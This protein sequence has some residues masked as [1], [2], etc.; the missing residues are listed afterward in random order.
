MKLH[1]TLN[2]IKIVSHDNIDN[3]L[4]ICIFAFI[5][6]LVITVAVAGTRH[7]AFHGGVSIFL[8]VDAAVDDSD[9][10]VGFV[11]AAVAA[12]TAVAAVIVDA[13]LGV[14]RIK[15]TPPA[16]AAAAE[17][18]AKVAADNVVVADVVANVVAD[19]VSRHV[20]VVGVGVVI[21]SDSKSLFE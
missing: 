6:Y 9:D 14:D 18:G 13:V 3:L 7:V 21:S 19:V 17:F 20:T 10:V 8:K 4:A 2:S 16:T 11:V 12:V 5:I 15:L 1:L